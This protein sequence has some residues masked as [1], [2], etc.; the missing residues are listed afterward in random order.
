MRYLHR[1]RCTDLFPTYYEICIANT[2]I[3]TKSAFS[4][5]HW[6]VVSRQ[7]R[8]VRLGTLESLKS[9]SSVLEVKSLPHTSSVIS[10]SLLLLLSQGKF[11]FEFVLSYHAAGHDFDTRFKT[12]I[13]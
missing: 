12:T 6:S 10:L 2:H 7:P 9:S 3:C 11:A 1:K 13:Y 5:Q 8:E 4:K